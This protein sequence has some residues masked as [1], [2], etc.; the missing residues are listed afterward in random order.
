MPLYLM[1]IHH[2]G[3]DRSATKARWQNV[4]NYEQPMGNIA[5]KHKSAFF[6]RTPAYV[7]LPA[8]ILLIGAVMYLRRERVG[9]PFSP[10]GVVMTA[11]LSYFNNYTTY[12]IWL[13]IIIVLVV[14]R[15]IYRWFGVGFFRRKVI[16]VLMFLMM[17]LMTGMFIYKLVFAAL[18]KGFLRPY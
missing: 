7:V 3:F 2:Y 15:I 5:Y 4:Y 1:F 13:P 18:G 8:G 10:V 14:K 11:G 16:P 9:F 12:V 17:G 6:N